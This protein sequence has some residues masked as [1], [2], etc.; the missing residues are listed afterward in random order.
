MVTWIARNPHPVVETNISSE[1]AA[2]AAIG[3]KWLSVRLAVW[4]EIIGTVTS[5]QNA[6]RHARNPRRGLDSL[7]AHVLSSVGAAMAG[8][9]IA[10]RIRVAMLIVWFFLS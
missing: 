7:H 2:A 5:M 8:P 4:V 10:I 9:V 3:E 1:E 6:A